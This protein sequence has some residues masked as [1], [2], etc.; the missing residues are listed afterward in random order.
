MEPQQNE[1]QHNKMQ[2]NELSV[3]SFEELPAASFTMSG[4]HAARV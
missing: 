3:T 4:R 1:M 2:Q